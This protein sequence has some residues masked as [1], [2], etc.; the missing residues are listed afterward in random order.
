MAMQQTG[1]PARIGALREWTGRLRD[2]SDTVAARAGL[3]EEKGVSKEARE[4]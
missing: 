1:S 4:T 3:D 2:R